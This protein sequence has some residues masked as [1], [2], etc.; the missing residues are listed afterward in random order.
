[1][2]SRGPLKGPWWDPG[3]KPWRGPGGGQIVVDYCSVIDHDFDVYAL[4]ETWFNSDDDSYLIDLDNYS[5]INCIRYGRTGGGTSLFI[6]SKHN[7]IRRPDLKINATDCDSIFIEISGKD[8][9]IGAIYKPEY[10]DFD[11]FISQLDSVLSII[12]KENK[13]CYIAGD[14]NLDLLNCVA[15]FQL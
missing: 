3:A 9:I 1:M 4:T 13:R 5:N 15:V 12:I 2:G 8:I 14:F 10:V 6:R 7:F 11:Q